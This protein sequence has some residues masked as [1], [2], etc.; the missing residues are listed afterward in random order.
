MRRDEKAIRDRVVLEAI[1]GRARVCRLA[2]HAPDFPYIVPMSFG[3]RDGTLYFHSAPSGRKLDLLQAD[4]RVGF[5]VEDCAEVLPGGSAC[6]WTM[7]YRSVIGTGRVHFISEE[8]EKVSAL[9]IIM[10]Q[11]A[12]G[13]FSFPPETVAATTVFAVAIEEMTGKQSRMPDADS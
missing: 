10:A 4:G 8:G 13:E 7:R 5:E 1:L 2:L 11:Y 12:P 9:E 3:Y 6:Q